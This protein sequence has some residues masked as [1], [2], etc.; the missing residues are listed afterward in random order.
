MDSLG[1]LTDQLLDEFAL[2]S[3]LG[4]DLAGDEI[5]EG[6]SRCSLCGMGDLQEDGF[7]CRYC[8]A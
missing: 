5:V 3:V 7:D 4:E 1:V 8:G 2:G 6:C